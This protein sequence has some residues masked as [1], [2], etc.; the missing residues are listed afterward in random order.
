VSQHLLNCPQVRSPVEQVG[1]K[2]VSE[3]VRADSGTGPPCH[4]LLYTT[5]RQRTAT[6]V[7]KER[8]VSSIER[9][10]PKQQGAGFVQV[11]TQ[12]LERR[13]THWYQPDFSS[14]AQNT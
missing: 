9:S 12:R 5:G 7:E 8:Q 4:D 11:C 2:G 1:G 6:P 14:F 13:L 10:G 3:H